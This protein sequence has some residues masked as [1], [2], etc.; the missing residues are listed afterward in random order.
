MM[1]YSL[2]AYTGYQDDAEH[3]TGKKILQIV[4]DG[5]YKDTAVCHTQINWSTPRAEKI[6]V[7]PEGN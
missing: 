3:G 5:R 2:K 4:L 7:H 6:Y 1:A